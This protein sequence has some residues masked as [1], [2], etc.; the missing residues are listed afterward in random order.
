MSTDETTWVGFGI[1]GTLESAPEPIKTWA[2]D[3]ESDIDDSFEEWLLANGLDLLTGELGGDMVYG[4]NELWS[5]VAT[6]TIATA[7]KGTYEI[8]SKPTESEEAQIQ[9]AGEMLGGA[10]A[11]AWRIQ[12]DLG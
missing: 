8:V 10:Y 1:G 6:S 9:I 7:D 2:E 3:P 12:T 11:P 5:I 4:E